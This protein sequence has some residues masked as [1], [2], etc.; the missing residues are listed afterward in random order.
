ML[1]DTFERQSLLFNSNFKDSASRD[2]PVTGYPE[3]F[4]L[5]F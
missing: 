5:K 3:L 4:T 2:K 1:L